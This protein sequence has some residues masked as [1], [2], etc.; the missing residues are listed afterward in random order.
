LKGWF[1]RKPA[2]D[3][4]TT[5]GYFRK[6]AEGIKTALSNDMDEKD[7][8]KVHTGNFCVE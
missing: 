1:T 6:T 4:Y 8:T 5:D 7:A 2:S 3:V